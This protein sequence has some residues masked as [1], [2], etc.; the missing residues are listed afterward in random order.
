[1]FPVFL[2]YTGCIKEIARKNYATYEFMEYD[3]AIF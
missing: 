1:M 3:F 2:Y